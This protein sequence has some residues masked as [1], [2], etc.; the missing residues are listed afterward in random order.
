M[1]LVLPLE[2]ASKL[3]PLRKPFET[4]D[5][6]LLILAGLYMLS[7]YFIVVPALAL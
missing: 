6:L 1:T 7:A 3:A 2:N 4:L 5:A